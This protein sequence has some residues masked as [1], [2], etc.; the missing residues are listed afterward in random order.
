MSAAELCRLSLDEAAE[1]VK[2][3]EASPV[4]LTEAALARIDQLNP[5]LNAFITVTA[6]SALEEARAAEREIAGGRYRGPLHGI[7]LS[8]KDLYCTKGVRT[9]GGSRLLR[10]FVPDEDATAAR[11]LRES[12][13]VLLGKNAMLELAYG[14]EH[15]DYGAT[16]NPWD[17]EF[18][19]NGS[20]SGSAAAVAAGLGYGSLG[21]DTGGS[22]RLP[23]A[24]CGI[25]GLKPSYGLVSRAGVLPLSWSLDHAGPMTRTVRDCAL[26]LQAIAGYD[27]AD[28]TSS[29]RPVPDYTAELDRVPR[30][31]T[32]GVFAAEPDDGV[33]PEVRAALDAATQALR[34]AGI[35][36]REVRQP[37][38][39]QAARALLAL[40][41]AEA[42]S[43]HLPWLRQRPDDYSA[44]TRERLELGALLPA[45]TYLSAQRARRTII[46]AYQQLMREV[47]ILLTPPAPTASYRLGGAS[48]A[49][50]GPE[51][52]RMGRLI[53]FSGP[54]DLTGL[55]AIAVPAGLTGEGL[56]LGVQLAAR[57]FAE[58][59]LFQ[60]AQVVEQ[61]L[62][63]RLPRPE[64]GLVV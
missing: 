43:Y 55:P 25:V 26:L 59:T 5:I 63:D 56:P 21:S 31:L 60:A 23:A 28:P 45:T 12:G 42:S 54:F 53:R 18:G 1:L 33:L 40:L 10:D 20:S 34:D 16:R 38:P 52:D 6:E 50:V 37:H 22:I 61:A 58:A 24:W 2:R 27:P 9:T 4:A 51:G 3:R 15:P 46:A 48:I 44:N 8:L 64:S 19:T 13:A 47:D 30:D 7:P 57:P 17:I 35:S 49:P 41:Y 36:V 39:E 32:A 29:R 14:E 11:K 62:K